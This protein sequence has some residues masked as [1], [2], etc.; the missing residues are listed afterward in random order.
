MSFLWDMAQD[1]RIGDVSSKASTARTQAQ[2]AQ[3]QAE[4]LESRLE[5]LQLASAAMW[6]LLRDRLGVTE[7][8]LIERMRQ[9]D[10]LD[11]KADGKMSARVLECAACKRTMSTRFRRCVYCGTPIAGGSPFPGV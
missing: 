10:L 4:Q 5:A 6:S 8:E 9:I 1:K 7:A 2:T 3:E 11:G